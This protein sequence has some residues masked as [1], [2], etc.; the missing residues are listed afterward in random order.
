MQHENPMLYLLYA[1]ATIGIKNVTDP[2]SEYD[3]EINVTVAV[4]GDR[5]A[6]N[7]MIVARLNAS[8]ATI[9]QQYNFLVVNSNGFEIY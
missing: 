7:A 6:N 4:E 8:S 1:D 3:K 9:G 2:V 5:L